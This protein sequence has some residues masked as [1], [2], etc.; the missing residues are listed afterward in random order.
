M[1]KYFEFSQ[2]RSI[3]ASQHR[4]IA[5]SQHRNSSNINYSNSR[6]VKM[7]TL[8]TFITSLLL[9]INYTTYS[10]P[11]SEPVICNNGD[12]TYWEGPLTALTFNIPSSILGCNEP[13]CVVT[14]VYYKRVTSWG[15]EVAVKSISFSGTCGSGCYANAFPT[16]LWMLSVLYQKN[17]GL[18]NVGDCYDNFT[19][20]I[21]T[22][23]EPNTNP[24]A[25][26]QYIAC[27]SE[28]CISTYRICLV[29]GTIVSPN[30]QIQRIGISSPISHNC[31]L[32]CQF[33]DCES[34]SPNF[35]EGP[36][37]QD[38]GSTFVFYPKQNVNNDI[39]VGQLLLSPN[40]VNDNLNL[41]ISNIKEGNYTLK[42]YDN[43]GNSFISTEIQIQSANSII[44]N[45]DIKELPT[46]KYNLIIYNND[47]FIQ[48]KSFIIVK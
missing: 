44:K 14:I 25:L 45:F 30:I 2:H 11:P 36:S 47:G 43:I 24:S 39:E 3:A 26:M 20:R 34:T 29:E 27:E 13:G 16:A 17:M 5:A 33:T 32:P 35:I 18:N 42:I 21:A 4:S 41:T 1:K 8:L 28:C 23:W 40:V 38:N 9:F 46:G 22:C 7:L 10:Q 12:S 31:I 19:Y 15:F 37:R 6:I 48:T